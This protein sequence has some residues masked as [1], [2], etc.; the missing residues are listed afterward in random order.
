MQAINSVAKMKSDSIPIDLFWNTGNEKES[1]MHRIHAYPAKFPAFITTK[2]LEFAKTEGISVDWVADIFCGC[3]TV[4]YEAKRNKINF[5]GCD[6]N[7]VATMIAR[8]KSQ[9]YKPKKLK[10]YHESILKEYK[11]LAK[12]Q[13]SYEDANDRLKYWYENN[14]FKELSRLKKAITG[15]VPVRSCYR[16][17]F[18]CAFSNILKPASRWL[19][20][21]IKPQVDPKKIPADVLSA[22]EEQCR[23]MMAANDESD[24]T[25]NSQ[26]NIVTANFLDGSVKHPT[27]DIIITSPPYV[28]SYEYADL[29]QLSALWLSY[30]DDYRKLRD[31]SIGSD[32]HAYNFEKEIKRL[33]TTGT[34]IVFRLLNQDK[35]KARS[36][37]KYFLDMQQVAQSCLKMLSDKGMALFVVG[38][39]EYKGVR[40]DNAKHLMES[41]LA[42]GFKEVCVTKRKITGKTLTP[43]RDE[44]G[45]FTTDKNSRKVYGEEFILIGRKECQNKDS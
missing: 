41:L 36:V 10:D 15:A 17:F 39:T 33:N 27:V 5:W 2:A 9:K 28:T 44:V 26:T 6:V 18:I 20:K 25:G 8:T 35:A 13:F 30:A 16:L 45:R 3:G 38:N 37:A 42:S 34:N 23:F 7:P 32:Y 12:A 21:S 40:I 19:T 31:G 11:R 24:A 29:H 43:Y 1:K 4:A 14:Q 22:F